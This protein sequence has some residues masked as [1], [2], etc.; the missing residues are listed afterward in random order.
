[1]YIPMTV[2]GDV[3]IIGFNYAQFVCVNIIVIM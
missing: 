1:M 3:I 2:D